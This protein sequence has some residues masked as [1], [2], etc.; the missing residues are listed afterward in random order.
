VNPVSDP[1]GLNRFFFVGDLNQKVFPKQASASGDQPAL[2]RD[3]DRVQQADVLDG[4]RQGPEI[5]QVL[6]E[7]ATHPD[8]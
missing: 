1:G 5:A 4:R 3:H 7:T 8:A 2:R 6:A